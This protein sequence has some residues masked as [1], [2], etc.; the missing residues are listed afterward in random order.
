[1]HSTECGQLESLYHKLVY[2]MYH[3]GFKIR[4]GQKRTGQNHMARHMRCYRVH[5]RP[6]ASKQTAACYSLKWPGK[7]RQW[8]SAVTCASLAEVQT[9]S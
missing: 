8:C 3:V 9:S 7:P 1:M 4:A 5:C 2:M 6:L